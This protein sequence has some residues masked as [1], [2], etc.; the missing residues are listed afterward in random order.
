MYFGG[1]QSSFMTLDRLYSYLSPQQMTSM[2]VCEDWT[3][4]LPASRG[5]CPSQ[6][7]RMQWH[8]DKM[9]V[10]PFG[11]RFERK[12][13][14]VNTSTNKEVKVTADCAIY[15]VGTLSFEYNE[16]MLLVAT[17]WTEPK[18]TRLVTSS[19]CVYVCKPQS[20]RQTERPNFGPN[21]TS[22]TLIDL[23][24]K[25]RCAWQKCERDH[26]QR[27]IR[28]FRYCTHAH[29]CASI[30]LFTYRQFVVGSG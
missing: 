27:Q 19:M 10:R 7:N 23:D 5:V 20:M 3:I 15:C 4:W 24:A 29:E 9:N 25:P 21:P 17:T 18:S 30:Y 13:L 28:Y 14:V 16:W 11:V 8:Q 22:Q 1:S 2:T 6:F 26:N 12:Q